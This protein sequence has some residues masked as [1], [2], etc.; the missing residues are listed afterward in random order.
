L[1]RSRLESET[2]NQ[3]ALISKHYT[4][5]TQRVYALNQYGTKLMRAL[6]NGVIC[7][8]LVTISDLH[9]LQ[10]I[11]SMNITAHFILPKTNTC[12]QIQLNTINLIFGN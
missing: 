3:S 1:T 6:F 4:T 12:Y 5:K 2:E 9:W 8:Q 10:P 7:K 11:N